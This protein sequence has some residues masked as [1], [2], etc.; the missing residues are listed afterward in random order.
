MK[1]T[2]RSQLPKCVRHIKQLKGICVGKCVNKNGCIN[3]NHAAHAHPYNW[4]SN[5]GWI[6]LRYKY[7]LRQKLTLLHEVAHLIANFDPKTPPHGRKW[8]QA[9]IKI[10][11]TFKEYRY[12]LR[13]RT[14]IHIDYTYRNNMI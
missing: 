9:V 10:G 3:K 12:R 13:G 11:G 2:K 6:C 8:K 1:I 4:D 7:R 5:Q 14:Y